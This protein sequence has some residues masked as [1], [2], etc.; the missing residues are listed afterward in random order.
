M[1]ISSVSKRNDI[2]SPGGSEVA[3]ASRHAA[4]LVMS[5]APGAETSTSSM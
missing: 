3:S 5:G 1:A 2:C 4:L